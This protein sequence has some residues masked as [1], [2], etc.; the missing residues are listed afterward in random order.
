[1]GWTTNTKHVP[2]KLR[3]ACLQRDNHQCTA[4]MLNGQRCPE[5]TNLEADHIH[6]WQ[7]DEQLTV[8]ELQT[9]CTWHHN[10]KT[11][12]QATAARKAKAPP[13]KRRNNKH[14]GLI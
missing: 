9:L 10:Q 5:T 7:Q 14:P 8:E 4:T 12:K 13:T 3:N 2:T 6:G 11:Q 1:M